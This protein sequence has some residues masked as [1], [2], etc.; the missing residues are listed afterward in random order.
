MFALPN[1]NYFL[2]LPLPNGLLKAWPAQSIHTINPESAVVTI[3]SIS[4]TLTSDA[5]CEL[6]TQIAQ[7]KCELATKPFTRKLTSDHMQP[8]LGISVTAMARKAPPPMKSQYSAGPTDYELKALQHAER[9]EKA[10]L[11]MARSNSQQPRKRAELKTRSLEEQQEAAERNKVYQARY[12]EKHRQ[13]LRIWEA[14][15]RR[16]VYKAKFGP[17]AYAAWRQAKRERRRRARAKL[18]AKEAYHSGDEAEADAD[19][20][21]PGHAKH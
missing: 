19:H 4:V 20:P 17:E 12:R 6:V 10:R 18:R 13:D 15:R 8:S 7:P 1:F 11:R 14:L 21:A 16:E 3:F 9:N 5:I 2:T